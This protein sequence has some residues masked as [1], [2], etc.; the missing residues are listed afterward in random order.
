M[1]CEFCREKAGIV[2]AKVAL[3]GDSKAGGSGLKRTNSLM[4]QRR[5]S[6]L[7]TSKDD[8]EVSDEDEI[9]DEKTAERNLTGEIGMSLVSQ[10]KNQEI[11]DLLETN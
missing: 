6:Q 11:L 1:G 8:R 7:S 9:I 3:A 5:P 10:V 4:L 2:D